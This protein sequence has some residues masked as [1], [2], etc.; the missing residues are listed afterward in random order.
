[1]AL[2]SLS[3]VAPCNQVTV[4]LGKNGAGKSTTM[5]LLSGMLEPTSGTCL[6]GEHNIA[7]QT[8]DAR[9]FLGLCPQFL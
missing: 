9:K 2:N 3:F 7:T 8:T 1:M 4:L 6:V 5:N